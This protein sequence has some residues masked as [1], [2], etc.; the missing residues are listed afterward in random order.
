MANLT[1]K[2]KDDADLSDSEA[3]DKKREK[4]FKPFKPK[5]VSYDK[6]INLVE[7]VID[8]R[9]TGQGG[10]ILLTG[11]PGIGKTTFV[12]M[13]SK[14]T[15]VPVIIVEVPHVTEEHLINIPF[16][17]FDKGRESKSTATVDNHHFSVELARS[18]L[19]AALGRLRKTPED[20]L[21]KYINQSPADM[22]GIWAQMG[23]SDTEIPEDIEKFRS[24]TNGILFL[25]EFFRQASG[26]IRNILRD[27]L[28]GFIGTDRMPND[29]Y[30]IYASN[31]RDAGDSIEPMALNNEFET[32]EFD[33]P[34]K[35]EWFSWFLAKFEKDTRVK[36]KKPVVDVFYN[37]I[38]DEHLSFNDVDTEIRTSPRRWEQMLLFINSVLPIENKEQGRALMANLKANFT[39]VQGED[40]VTSKLFD[41]VKKAVEL[42]IDPKNATE[43]QPLASTSWRTT[44]MQQ[45]DVKKALGEH[46]AYIPILQGPPGIGKTAQAASVAEKE[47]MLLITIDC[48]SLSQEDVTGIPLPSKDENGKME[49]KFEAPKLY[50]R[51]MNQIHEQYDKYK[52]T[53]NAE[54]LSE[55]NKQ[56]FKYLLLMDEFNRVSN[57]NTFNALRRVVLEKSFNHK[58]K[59]P[60]G[61]IIIGA[62]NPFDRMTQDITGHMKDVVDFID[63][64][65]DWNELMDIMS[66][67]SNSS[68]FKTNNYSSTSANISLRVINEFFD[69]F[70]SKSNGKNKGLNRFT[71]SSKNAGSV[72]VSPREIFRMYRSMTAAVDRVMSKNGNDDV[73]ILVKKIAKAAY[74]RLESTLKTVYT[75]HDIEAPEFFNT[76][77]NWFNNTDVITKILSKKR[78]TVTLS[79][80][81]T[82]II[83][84]YPN[85]HLK[86]DVNFTNYIQTFSVNKFSVDFGDFIDNFISERTSSA[87]EFFDLSKD[88]G[89][90]QKREL[91]NQ[92]V[93]VMKDTV[94]EME[95][96]CREIIIAAKINRLDATLIDQTIKVMEQ[97]IREQFTKGRVKDVTDATGKILTPSADFFTFSTNNSKMSMSLKNMAKKGM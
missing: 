3:E 49:T 4:L 57:Q 82:N 25:D 60:E 8:N 27:I 90:Y 73:D 44:L 47:N 2:P 7:H 26:N 59:L 91:E 68:E 93:T 19:A 15:G 46:R 11:D 96:I 6:T 23:G 77:K 43:I 74:E 67:W 24:R 81:L 79:D 30:T 70:H 86:D 35:S 12:R 33:A 50:I 58:D 48:S 32:R 34:N 45:I 75:K 92:A 42:L 84:S 87:K 36:L 88:Q 17:I 89:K 51:I 38:K 66:N 55:F 78:V 10:G 14:L 37:A 29:V 31:M 18:N 9:F 69:D 5:N 28:N 94:S 65:P 64:H 52:N 62:M 53:H 76:V 40:S 71:L 63:S 83:D 97:T 13:F 85:V 80:I 56:E 39:A 61:T 21:L 54:E 41:G 1:K 16:V 72:Y 20:Q 95:F 22:K